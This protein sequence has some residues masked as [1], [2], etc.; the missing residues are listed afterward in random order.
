MTHKHRPRQYADPPLCD[1]KRMYASE[2]E[3]RE[4]ADQQELLNFGQ[5]LELN[6][7]RCIKCGKWHLTRVQKDV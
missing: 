2:R 3:A 6:T 7:Y 5:E 1:G 4:I